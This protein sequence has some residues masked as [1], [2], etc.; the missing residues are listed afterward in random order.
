MDLRLSVSAFDLLPNEEQTV[1]N[2]LFCSI[3]LTEKE[4][5]VAAPTDKR[6]ALVMELGI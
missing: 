1:T 6:Q 5:E 2:K 4:L 3:A